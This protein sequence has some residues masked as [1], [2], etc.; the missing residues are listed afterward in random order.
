MSS[1]SRSTSS[2]LVWKPYSMS[3]A[4]ASVFTSTVYSSW[5]MGLSRTSTPASRNRSTSAWASTFRGA[6]M[7]PELV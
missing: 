5:R 1:F 3:T 7:G 6:V 2:L 4:G